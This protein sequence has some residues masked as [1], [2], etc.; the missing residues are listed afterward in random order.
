MIKTNH[1]PIAAP[2]GLEYKYT[3]DDGEMKNIPSTVSKIEKLL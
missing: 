3:Q 2:A 1:D